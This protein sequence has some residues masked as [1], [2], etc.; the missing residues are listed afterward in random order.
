MVF[1][2]GV[3]NAPGYVSIFLECLDTHKFRS[4]HV[5][6][7]MRVK[8]LRGAT[9]DVSNRTC[10]FIHN[11]RVSRSRRFFPILDIYYNRLLAEILVSVVCGCELKSIHGFH[12]FFFS[13][14]LLFSS[15]SSSLSS[16]SSSFA[17][18]RAC[19]GSHAGFSNVFDAANR[20][21]GF[22]KMFKHSEVQDFL[23]DGAVRM[24]AALVLWLQL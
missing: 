22:P 6:C 17:C 18:V 11:F 14:S 20:D 15:S 5:D 23:V 12:F 16:S 24:P 4:K 2:R 21:F 10:R 3:G 19:P 8:N 13:S 7:T 1:P 9:L